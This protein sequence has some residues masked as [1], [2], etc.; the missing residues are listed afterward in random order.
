MQTKTHQNKPTPIINNG[1]VKL[2]TIMIKNINATQQPVH[3]KCVEK[4]SI[5]VICVNHQVSFQPI[6]SILQCLLRF[7]LSVLYLNSDLYSCA[8]VLLIDVYTEV[9]TSFAF[10]R[11]SNARGGVVYYLDTPDRGKA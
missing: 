4:I 6:L 8:P 3:F 7:S 1:H 9:H 10:C 5:S 11:Q 2:L